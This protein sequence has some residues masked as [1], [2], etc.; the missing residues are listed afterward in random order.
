MSAFIV[1]KEI[2][3]SIV[4]YVFGMNMD[5]DFFKRNTDTQNENELG[6]F[7]W[8]VNYKAVNQRYNE[9]DSPEKYTFQLNP[10]NP[11]QV[12]KFLECLLYQCSEGDVYESKEFRL[13]EQIQH[14]VAK[15]IIEL[16]PQYKNAEWG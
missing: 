16:T 15:R 14:S 10:K 11:C 4:T 6:Q 7:L 12:Y 3:D 1:E 2:I 9:D 13:I 5:T 8:D